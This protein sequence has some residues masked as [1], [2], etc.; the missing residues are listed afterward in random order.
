MNASEWMRLRETLGRV[1]ESVDA[2]IYTRDALGIGEWTEETGRVIC[3][4]SVTYVGSVQEEKIIA[5]QERI[6]IIAQEYA[7]DAIALIVG[8]SILVKGI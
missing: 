7:Q 3:E 5:L 4:E 8:Q 6:Q 2:D 1:L